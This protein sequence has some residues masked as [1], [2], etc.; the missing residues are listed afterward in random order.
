VNKLID[1]LSF[2]FIVAGITVLTRPGSQGPSL[3]KNLGDAFSSIVS[4]STGGGSYHIPPG[5]K[6]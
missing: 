1:V 3:V 4:A 2:A 6:A 5:S